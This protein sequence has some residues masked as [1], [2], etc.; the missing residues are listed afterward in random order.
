MQNAVSYKLNHKNW[1]VWGL[2]YVLE[3]LELVP[4]CYVVCLKVKNH[5]SSVV[6]NP[7]KICN[8]WFCLS[9]K[10]CCWT[11]SNGLWCAPLFH[12]FEVSVLVTQ[13]VHSTMEGCLYSNGF[14]LAEIPGNMN[15]GA[16]ALKSELQ[17]AELNWWWMKGRISGQRIM[18]DVTIIRAGRY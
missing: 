4:T 9:L 14:H 10:N 13:A 11:H 6:H 15:S 1:C 18:S 3:K 16:K 8:T 17:I 7:N 2:R 12:P 5:Q